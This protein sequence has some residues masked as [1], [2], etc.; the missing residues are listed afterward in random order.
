MRGVA[1]LAV[2]V[3][4]RRE[5][6]PTDLLGHGYLGVDFFFILSGFVIGYAYEKRLLEGRRPFLRFAA[7]RFIRLMPLL[8]LGVAVGLVVAIINAL[9]AHWRGGV[10]RAIASVPLAIIPLPSPILRLPWLLD[11][12]SW[13][14][15]FELAANFAFALA[16][17]WL[18]RW[19]LPFALAVAAIPLIAITFYANSINFGR[20]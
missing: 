18:S 2:L 15:F 7:T 8:A 16:V 19:R 5:L 20:A 11:G 14:L 3:F 1:A 9:E 13:S 17:P 10:V 12:P 6:L 4:H